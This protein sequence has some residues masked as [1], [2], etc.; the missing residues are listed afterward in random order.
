MSYQVT[1]TDPVVTW[2]SFELEKQIA[3]A[4]KANGITND[5]AYRT[6]INGMAAGSALEKASVQAI[7]LS[8]KLT[9]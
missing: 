7:M 8:A 1:S 3:I 6:A 9:P 4:C 5:V 2:D